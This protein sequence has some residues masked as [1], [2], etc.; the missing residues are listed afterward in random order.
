MGNILTQHERKD[1]RKDEIEILED[2]ILI[3]MSA[4]CLGISVIRSDLEKV[5]PLGFQAMFLRS[6]KHKLTQY[7]R[8]CGFVETENSIQCYFQGGRILHLMK[9][10]D[11]IIYSLTKFELGNSIVGKLSNERDRTFAIEPFADYPEAIEFRKIIA[12]IRL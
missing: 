6:D 10:G 3:P 4:S 9:R 5:G 2:L 12:F 11:D 7:Y 8:M 1:E